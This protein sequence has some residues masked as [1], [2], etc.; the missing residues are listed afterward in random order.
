MRS[1]EVG[2]TVSLKTGG[3]WMC[4]EFVGGDG[5]TRCVWFTQR[6][7][8][9]IG[10]QRGAFATAQLLFPEQVTT[11]VQEP[12]PGE[13]PAYDAALAKAKELRKK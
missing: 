2:D 3:P 9:W 12:Q 4:V 7:G 10:P 6:A 5:T 1:V 11:T 13:D 8:E